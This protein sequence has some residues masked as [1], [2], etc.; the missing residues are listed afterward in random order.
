MDK[1]LLQHYDTITEQKCLDCGWSSDLCSS[2]PRVDGTSDKSYMESLFKDIG[3]HLNTTHMV[4]ADSDTFDG[5]PKRRGFKIASSALRCIECNLLQDDVKS[6]QEHL[7]LCLKNTKSTIFICFCGL[8][9]T[10]RHSFFQHLQWVQC[11]QIYQQK[12]MQQYTNGA[13]MRNG[14]RG[15]IPTTPVQ[16]TTTAKETLKRSPPHQ[17]ELIIN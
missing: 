11:K 13:F 4:K 7:K 12:F 17:K 14:P 3:S 16:H 1:H 10:D 15:A 5:P 9:F 8:E 6:L 2:K